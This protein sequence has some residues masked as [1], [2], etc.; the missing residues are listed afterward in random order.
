MIRPAKPEDYKAII[1][2]R[3]LL[4][5]DL[6]RLDNPDYRLKTQKSGF[7]LPTNLTYPDFNRSMQTYSV[8]EEEGK[9]VAYTKVDDK[10]D[11]ASGSRMLW[12]EPQWEKLYY[13]KPHAYLY[14]IGVTPEAR[15]RGIAS[16]MLKPILKKARNNCPYLF[17]IVVTS[18]ILNFASVMFHESND[19]QRIAN[20][21]EP[22]PLFKSSQYQATLYVKDLGKI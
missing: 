7:L 9:I 4:A 20:V 19:F 11:V 3:K 12:F 8:F 2:I 5:L 1:K 14:G 13:D 6:S 16:E 18:P 17:S 15:H 22:L 10:Q 21:L